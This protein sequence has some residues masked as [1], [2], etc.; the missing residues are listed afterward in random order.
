[1][2]FKS[3]L[4]FG[5]GLSLVLLFIS[6]LAS[7]ISIKNLIENEQLLRASNNRILTLN[8]TLSVVKDAETGQRGYLLTGDSR[9]LEPYSDSK[10]KINTQLEELDANFMD[11]PSQQKDLSDLKAQIQ[12]RIQILEKNLNLKLQTGIVS[13]ENLHAGKQYMGEIRR[14][15]AL[16]QKREEIILKSRTD[17]MKKFAGF[18][19]W[20]IILSAL[21][22]IAITLIFFRK[23]LQDFNQKSEL[24]QKLEEKNEETQNRLQAIEKVAGQISSGNYRICIR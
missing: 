17:T 14:I 8:E 12:T 7:Y 3:N 21:L 1:M 22:A 16:M 9:F 11:S 23:V 24:T 2:N 5:L 15:V 6:S 13:T 4:I 20:L 19:P 18:T 10:R